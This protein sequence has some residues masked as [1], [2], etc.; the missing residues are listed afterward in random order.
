[1][2]EKIYSW[3]F[4]DNKNRW[5]LWYIIALSIVFGISIWGFFTKQYWLSFIILFIAW[6]TF[7]VENNSEDKIIV[8]IT[9]LWVI[10]AWILYDYSSINSFW[11]IYKWVDPILL[12]LNLNKKWINQINVKI[13][14]KNINDIKYILLDYIEEV[15][16][17][18]LTFSEKMIEILKL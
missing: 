7:Y 16:Q 15:P 3:E 18:E 6:L 1:M 4:N 14:T 17:I 12:R 2:S 10:I 8:Q 11:I 5:A 13:N 9:D